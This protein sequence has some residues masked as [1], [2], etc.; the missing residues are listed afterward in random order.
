MTSTPRPE[1]VFCRKNWLLRS[2]CPTRL[3]AW[4][5]GYPGGGSELYTCISRNGY[6]PVHGKP[7]LRLFTSKRCTYA[8]WGYENGELLP[9]FTT[10]ARL[11]W[12]D[13]S[14]WV[15][16]PSVSLLFPPPYHVHV[17]I[18]A[19]ITPGVTLGL[20]SEWPAGSHA[21]TDSLL[22]PRRTR[23]VSLGW[24]RWFGHRGQLVLNPVYPYGGE[25][26]GHLVFLFTIGRVRY[27]V[28]LH[29]WLPRL[30]VTRGAVSRVVRAQPGAALPHVIA[31][32]KAIVGSALSG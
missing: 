18:A 22:T 15:P 6:Q 11:D 10:G 4:G 14:R 31:T 21:V 23:A 25:W 16:L 1:L 27:A 29:A 9:G 7:L 32:L 3:P 17:E 19:T 5:S 8:D 28:T 2:I 20:G 26:G 12:W 30:R 24:V 13:A